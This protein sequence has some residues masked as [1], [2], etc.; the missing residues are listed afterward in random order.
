MN[1]KRFI[2]DKCCFYTDKPSDWERHLR[3]KKHNMQGEKDIS[4][5]TCGSSFGSRTTMWRHKKK[6]KVTQV[7]NTKSSEV[8]SELAKMMLEAAKAMQSAAFETSGTTNNMVIGSNNTNYINVN[9]FLNGECGDAMSIQNFARHLSLTID[10]LT[11]NKRDAIANIVIKNLKPLAVTERPVHCRDKSEWYIK[12]EDNGWSEDNGE[13]LIQAAA[14]G[15]QR[16]WLKEFESKYPFW[17]QNEKLKELYVKIAGTSSSDISEGEKMAIL[18][19]IGDNC[20]F[21]SG[22]GKIAL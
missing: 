9:M 6:C 20:K 18:N 13:S 17:M 19:A 12:D 16:N 1:N 21:D 10:D 4:C 15:I 7:N 11:T 8:T 5:P 3:T 22:I 2:C 14:F